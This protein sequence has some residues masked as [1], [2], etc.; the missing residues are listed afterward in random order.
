MTKPNIEPNS[1]PRQVVENI[2]FYS[3]GWFDGLL[4]CQ[5]TLIT[6]LDYW[7]GYSLGLR[8]YYAQKYNVTL[9]NSQ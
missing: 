6:N 8:E 4:G 5:P 2:Q 9:S 1:P 3:E 7:T